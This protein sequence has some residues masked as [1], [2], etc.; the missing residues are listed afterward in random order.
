MSAG[1]NEQQAQGYF[2][3]AL[4]AEIK[5]VL[6]AKCHTHLDSW[7][8]NGTIRLEPKNMG[9]TGVDVAWLTYQAVFTVEQLPF[10][11]LDPAI[12][13]ASVA[14]WVQEND[15]FRER[16]ELADPEYAVTPNDEKTADLEIQLA[17]T[18]PL[19]LIEHPKGHIN[20]M[21]K[22]WNVAPYEIWV[23]DHIDMNVG[24]T[25]HHQVSG[26]S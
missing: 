3:H 22:R 24:D 7:M 13:L 18:E 11:E 20:W 14:A 26:Q 19:R 10:R 16:F 8:E 23:A 4:H 6:P 9:P 1:V 2:L 17:F 15:E 5:R 21:G 12:V 25:G